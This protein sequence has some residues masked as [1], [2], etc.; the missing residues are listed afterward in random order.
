MLEHPYPTLPSTWYFDAGHHRRELDAIWWQEW[1]CVAR[2]SEFAQPG[3]FRIVRVGGQQVLITRTTS[4]SLRAFH[5]TCRHRGSLLC[6]T[7]AGQFAQQR[8]VC[9][10]HAWT[11]SLEGELL[12]TPRKPDAEGFGAEDHSLY[13]VLLETW[14]GY[15]FINLAEQASTSLASMIAADCA[16]LARWPLE[17]LSLA[18]QEAHTVECNWKVFWEN[19]LECYHCPNVHQDLC[20]LV[21]LYGEG[22]N[23]PDDL[24]A[25]SPLRPA[26]GGSRLR[27]G[28]VTWSPDGLTELPT[29]PGITDAE[30]AVGMTFANLWPSVFIVAHVDYVRSVHVLPLG[31]EQTQLTV[32]WM[33]LPE[34]LSSDGVDIARLTAFGRQVVLE[35]ARVCALNQ[36][37]LHSLRHRHGSLAPQEYDVLAFDNWVRKR[38]GES[39]IT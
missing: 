33:L 17:K 15:V 9:P 8:I 10:Y 38:L 5:N 14:R 4:G 34:V 12:R 35:D 21:P 16:A 2:E 37:G 13:P 23:S 26:P 3:D 25:G 22:L 29:F 32:N 30:R 36:Q 31:P 7:A 19:F 24:P 1:L 6:E 20:R 27:P 18:H 28:A 39:E 11:Y